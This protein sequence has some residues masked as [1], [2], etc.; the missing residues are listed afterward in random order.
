VLEGEM[1]LIVDDAETILH[2]GDVVVQR[3]TDHAWANRSDRA[4]RMAFVLVGGEF[5]DELR[6]IMPPGATERLMA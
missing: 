3:G 1:V 4:A 5:T 2:P 6:A